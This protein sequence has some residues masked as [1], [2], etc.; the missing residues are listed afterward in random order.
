MDSYP[1]DHQRGPSFGFLKLLFHFVCYILSWSILRNLFLSFG[2]FQDLLFQ[3]SEISYWWGPISNHYV[4]QWVAPSNQKKKML[5]PQFWE[6]FCNYSFDISFPLI[7]E[8]GELLLFRYYT[9]WVVLWFSELFFSN[10]S[11]ENLICAL[12]FLFLKNSIDF[13]LVTFFLW[14]PVLVSCIQYFLSSEKG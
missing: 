9:F 13:L 10:S 4:E 14:H 7:F 1:L 6:V 2:N 5:V 8:V 12:I 11:S 3:C